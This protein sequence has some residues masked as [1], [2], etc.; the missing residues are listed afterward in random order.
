[1][2]R[3]KFISQLAA[4]VRAD[5]KFYVWL[6]ALGV[7]FLVGLVGFVLVW[8]RGL[9][10]TNLTDEVPWGLWIV[11]DLSFVALGAGS[12]VTAALIFIFG[13]KEFEPLAR[14]AI[15]I[16]LAADTG[17]TLVLLADLGRPDRFYHP[18]IYWNISSLLWV[19][20]WCVILY[21]T[22]L[23]FELIP[24]LA[25]SRFTDRW[26][27]VKKIGHDFHHTAGPVVAVIGV[28]IG[29]IH[30]PAI[31]AAYSIVKGNPLWSNNAV[32]F[33]FL[34]TALFAGP[35]LL[36][37]VVSVTAWITDKELVPKPL[38]R[39]MA[40]IVGAIIVASLVI[41]VWDVAARYHFSHAPLLV[42]QWDL[43]NAETP[44]SLANTVGEFL[45]GG[46]IPA[47]IYL[48]PTANRRYGNLVIASAGTTIGLLLYRWNTTL[49]G[50]AV[51]VSF[52]P[53]DPGVKL[54][55]YFPSPIE[56]IVVLG[57]LAFTAM[58]Y[59]LGVKFLPIFPSG[60]DQAA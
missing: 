13:R 7:V 30:Q 32:P 35:S 53:S 43:L 46:I 44:Y 56:W 57:V 34:I 60:R 12:F 36:I 29:L 45:I 5:L 41:R 18:I 8:T 14:A 15:L 54:D 28:I 22:V 33:L 39:K 19:I 48:S 38:L 11:M 3:G 4:H 17:T 31:G 2:A 49:S 47:L 26:P 6:A 1:M 23:A 10:V 21:I 51:S 52:S 27:R 50:V 20:T 25:E 9:V 58:V 42:Q 55:S 59:S 24:I 16:G 40:R 37:G